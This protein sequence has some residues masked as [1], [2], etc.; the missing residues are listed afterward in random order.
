MSAEH[1]DQVEIREATEP[2]DL[3]AVRRLLQDYAEEFAPTIADN[4]RIQ[5]F[6][7]ELANLPGRY[8]GPSGGLLLA[9]VAGL[10]AGCVAVRDLGDGVCEMKRLYVAPDYRSIGLGKL[11]IAAIVQHA[12]R[13]GHR[14]MVLDSTP[15][16]ARAVELY[17]SFGFEETDPYN[18]S[19]HALFFS[20]PLA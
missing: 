3:E 13:L 18:D 9:T 14:R 17:R 5:R 12:T 19:T 15:E 11:L 20:R 10:S 16:M 8:A 6:D 2:G 4:L 1:R 7:E